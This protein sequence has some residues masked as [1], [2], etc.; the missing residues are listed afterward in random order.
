MSF[1]WGTGARRQKGT[2]YMDSRKLLTILGA[3]FTV[4][5]AIVLTIGIALFV[6]TNQKYAAGETVQAQIDRIDVY[7][8]RNGTGSN[9]S[10]STNY[11][12]YVSYEYDGKSYD[13][14]LLNSYDGSMYEGEQLE[15]LVDPERP[16][17]VAVPGFATMTLA[18]FGGSGALC[19]VT[20]LSLLIVPRVRRRRVGNLK[21]TGKR[22]DATVQEVTVLDN[23]TFN[24]VPGRQ[25]RCTYK[26]GGQN[27][28]FTS[29]CAYWPVE[30]ALHAGDHIDVY[31]NP[32]D[33]AKNYVDIPSADRL[34]SSKTYIDL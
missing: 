30:D 3:I 1:A 20:G 24:G 5:G 25:V 27:Y 29:A 32:N 10:T 13:D 11:D 14:V 8:T 33:Y 21:Q 26:E 12:V 7:R 23:R 31:V 2:R 4:I 9:S 18:G 17:N 28:R 16:G 34:P 6:S 22:L 19:L 15:L